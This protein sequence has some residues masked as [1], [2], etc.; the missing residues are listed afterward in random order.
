MKNSRAPRY[1]EFI[2]G[3]S[4]LN[5]VAMAIGNKADAKAH[6][7]S[8]S[9]RP[10]K[11]ILRPRSGL[12]HGRSPTATIKSMTSSPTP[13]T[14]ITTLSTATTTAIITDAPTKEKRLV[15]WKDKCPDVARRGM[16]GCLDECQEFDV[17][18][19]EQLWKR[20]GKVKSWKVKMRLMKLELEKILKA[21]MQIFL[22]DMWKRVGK[23]NWEEIR[24]KEEKR[25]TVRKANQME[26]VARFMED[27]A[28]KE[29]WLV[30]NAEMRR[31]KRERKQKLIENE[32]EKKKGKGTSLTQNESKP[33]E[34]ET[35]L[36]EDRTSKLESS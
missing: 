7:S 22:K 13:T 5:I 26:Q 34:K 30:E 1:I 17:S 8:L 23:E 6:V 36:T 3:L 19:E 16:L 4:N 9:T 10:L 20:S 28:R 11:L 18:E 35:I 32:R 31:K 29:E 25:T 24:E 27:K 2:R 14:D 12:F 21:R 33:T 15:R